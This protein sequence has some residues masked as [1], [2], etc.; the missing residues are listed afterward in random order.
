M[1]LERKAVNIEPRAEYMLTEAK[2]LERV[3]A[4]TL[5]SCVLCDIRVP[6]NTTARKK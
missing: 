5:F 2:I 6:N 1:D 4:G 3:K